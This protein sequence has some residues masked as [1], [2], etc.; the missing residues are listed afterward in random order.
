M[1]LLKM[2]ALPLIITLLVIAIIIGLSQIGSTLNNVVVKETV[3]QEQIIQ[4]K[5]PP[6]G[7]TKWK[8]K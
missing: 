8:Q 6:K 3:Y 4:I 7:E 5:T 1:E 2:L